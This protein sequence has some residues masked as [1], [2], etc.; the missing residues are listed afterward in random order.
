MRRF[1]AFALAM[2]V[3]G[4]AAVPAVADH[5]HRGKGDRAARFQQWL[6]LSEEQAREIRAIRERYRDS[7]RQVAT[8]LM[9]ARR[10]LSRL[11]LEGA[12]Q[13][14]L[15]AKQQEI[16][17]LTRQMMELRVQSLRE[18]G[19]LLTA[20]QREKLAQHPV[21]PRGWRHKHRQPQGGTPPQG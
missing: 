19:P 11:A 2:A 17:E 16:A 21:G 13:G 20:E 18:I 4:A 9:T 7:L 8:A 5:A 14:A 1:V 12:D 15:Q 3:I 6:G 10:E